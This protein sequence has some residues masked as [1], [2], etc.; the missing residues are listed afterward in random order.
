MALLGELAVSPRERRGR[1][2]V[3]PH[4]SSPAT[5][6]SRGTGLR[7]PH[8]LLVRRSPRALN[9]PH[10]HL[11]R[12]RAGDAIKYRRPLRLRRR[13]RN[14]GVGRTRH[15]MQARIVTRRSRRPLR[16]QQQQSAGATACLRACLIVALWAEPAYDSFRDLGIS[17]PTGGSPGGRPEVPP[18][19]RRAGTSGG[20][21]HERPLRRRSAQCS[22][23]A[24]ARP[25]RHL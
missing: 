10:R 11:R 20:S 19:G 22:A 7:R 24:P 16:P 18:Q 13:S 25:R 5:G 9:P 2:Q 4:P 17:I 21:S 8:A 3:T 15:D 12:S 23:T 14:P 6:Q 1:P